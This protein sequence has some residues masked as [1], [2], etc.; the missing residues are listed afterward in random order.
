MSPNLED[1]NLDSTA[2]FL[3]LLCNE[4]VPNSLLNL[5]ENLWCIFGFLSKNL[6]IICKW[7]IQCRVKSLIAMLFIFPGI[8]SGFVF[9]FFY[10]P[11]CF[12]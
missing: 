11:G 1:Q 12:V 10:F 5:Y 3:R 4:Q 6:A 7:V 9:W 2:A 8:E